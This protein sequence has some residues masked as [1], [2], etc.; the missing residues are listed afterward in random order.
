MLGD[1]VKYSATVNQDVFILN[2]VL[3][4]ICPK[5]QGSP[6]SPVPNQHI[7]RNAEGDRKTMTGTVQLSACLWD[8]DP[9]TETL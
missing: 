4:I 3:E 1:I 7:N 6:K 8:D 9:E 2:T 5:L